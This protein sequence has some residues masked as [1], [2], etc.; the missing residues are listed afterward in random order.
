[1]TLQLA[2]EYQKTDEIDTKKLP[3]DLAEIVVVWP[4][5]PGH[6]KAAIKALVQ[7]QKGEKE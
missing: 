1:L 6:I 5:L 7:T 2:P 3:S 4:E